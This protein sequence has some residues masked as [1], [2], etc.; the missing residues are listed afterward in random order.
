MSL[1]PEKHKTA[2]RRS[3]EVTRTY[4]QKGQTATRSLWIKV[5]P[6][7]P[8]SKVIMVPPMAALMLTMLVLVLIILGF[9]LL[10]VALMQAVGRTGEKDSEG[11]KL[12]AAVSTCKTN[13]KGRIK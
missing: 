9:T 10:A 4:L 1:V 8:L 3:L 2:N 7:H 6:K 12:E 11:G 13:S 5:S